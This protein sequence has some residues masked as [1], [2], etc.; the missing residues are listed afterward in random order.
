MFG[1]SP[2][3]RPWFTSPPPHTAGFP[4]PLRGM[5]FLSFYSVRCLAVLGSHLPVL[6]RPAQHNTRGQLAGQFNS[7]QKVGQNCSS[8]LRE[9]NDG[10]GPVEV[11]SGLTA[12][13]KP[14]MPKEVQPHAQGYPDPAQREEHLPW[15]VHHANAMLPSA[16]QAGCVWIIYCGYTRLFVQ[17]D[18]EEAA[19]DLQSAAGAFVIDKTQLLELVHEMTDPRPGGAHHLRQVFL[20]DSGKDT[21]GSTFFAKMRQQQE[22]P[23]QTLL[24][25]VEELVDKILFV[26]Q[27]A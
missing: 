1:D 4:G 18:A 14:A 25:G 20:I 17:D 23:R 22:N 6:T 3:L 7:T 19:M 9:G 24:A 5:V 2:C 13:L 27:A 10:V 12:S 8:Q 16:G 21:L 11:V 26:S 15:R